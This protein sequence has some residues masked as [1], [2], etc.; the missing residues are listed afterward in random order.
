MTYAERI[1]VLNRQHPEWNDRQLAAE[2]GCS[3]PYVR[4]VAQ[5][6]KLLR[7]SSRIRQMPGRNKIT[8]RLDDGM[9]DWLDNE[10][11]TM[12]DGVTIN[13]VILSIL[14]DARAGD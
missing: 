7:G 2:V 5:R 3:M 12:G 9:V 6:F 13:D 8:V 10:A 4:V 14:R 1:V 11:A